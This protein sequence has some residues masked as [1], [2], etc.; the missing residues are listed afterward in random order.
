MVVTGMRDELC[1]VG[2]WLWKLLQ[3]GGERSRHN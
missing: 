2:Q 3:S 1:S